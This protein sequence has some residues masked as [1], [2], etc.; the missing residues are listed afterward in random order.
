LMSGHGPAEAPATLPTTSLG[1]FANSIEAFLKPI[2]TWIAYIGAAVLGLIT[3]AIVYS[4]IGRLFGAPLPGTQELI[5]QSLV[6][7]IFAAM[8]LE[9]MGHE[10]MSVDVLCN[11]LPKKVQ[12]IVAP[13]IYAIAVAIL[14]IAVWQLVSWGIRVQGRGQ[15]TIGVLALPLYPFAY[16]S[17]FGIATLIPIWLSRLLKSIDRAVKG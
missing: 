16:L 1:R 7:M 11:H 15:T 13:I 3:L 5:E 8:G 14:V 12:S 10:K 6:V 17:A 4:I 2:Y 9:H